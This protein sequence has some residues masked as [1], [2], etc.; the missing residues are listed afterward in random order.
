MKKLIWQRRKHSVNFKMESQK[1]D[2]VVSPSVNSTN[3]SEIKPANGK[4]MTV[5]SSDESLGKLNFEILHNFKRVLQLPS[6]SLSS[7]KSFSPMSGQ[8][9]SFQPKKKLIR[10]YGILK[11]SIAYF[12]FLTLQFYL[13]SLHG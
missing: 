11:R 7:L 1:E 8:N 6:Y 5:L 2:T 12:Y 10:L 4:I 13:S 9:N 3:N